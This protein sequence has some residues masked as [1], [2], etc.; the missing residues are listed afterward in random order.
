MTYIDWEYYSSLYT[1]VTDS[2]EFE[3]LL[4][5]AEIKLNTITSIS[6]QENALV[7]VCLI[8]FPFLSSPPHFVFSLFSFVRF[9]PVS[10][11]SVSVVFAVLLSAPAVL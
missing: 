3:R 5:L 6:S 8:L 9:L 1:V 2:K 7:F 11:Q 10:S 4:K